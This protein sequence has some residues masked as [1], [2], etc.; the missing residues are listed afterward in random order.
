MEVLVTNVVVWLAKVVMDSVLNLQLENSRNLRK[1][2][3]NIM[4]V[5]P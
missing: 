1:Y 4:I 3:I 5:R 2:E